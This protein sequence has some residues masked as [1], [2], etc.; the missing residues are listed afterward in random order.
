MNTVVQIPRKLKHPLI[1]ETA[2][3]FL[4]FMDIAVFFFFFLSSSRLL[5]GELL[6]TF[7]SPIHIL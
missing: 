3:Q 4:L 6:L 1:R 2:A 5:E 7:F